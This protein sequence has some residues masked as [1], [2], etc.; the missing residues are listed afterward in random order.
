M[1]KKRRNMKG[2]KDPIRKT[3]R[4]EIKIAERIVIVAASKNSILGEI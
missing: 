2:R 4:R 3:M 1:S